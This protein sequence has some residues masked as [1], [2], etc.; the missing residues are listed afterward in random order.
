MVI[1][2][3]IKKLRNKLFKWMKI[4]VVIYAENVG[5]VCSSFKKG[6]VKDFLKL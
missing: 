3:I 2:M 1:I 5:K 6:N 4:N